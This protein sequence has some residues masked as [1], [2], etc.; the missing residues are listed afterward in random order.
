MTHTTT[1]AKTTA[2]TL[3]AS[4][5]ATTLLPV[6]S[7]D[8][9]QRHGVRKHHGKQYNRNHRRHAPVRHQKRRSNGDLIAAGIIGLAVGA[10]IADSASKQRQTQPTYVYREPQ[11]SPSYRQPLNTYQPRPAY[12]EPQVIRYNERVSY[13]PWTQAWYEYC[14]DRYR[15]FNANTGTFR[16]YDGKDHFCVAE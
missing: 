13:E 14:D 10:I 4:L 16:G 15:S 5:L 7:A 2:L 3:A 1:L 12:R 11:Y 9:G 8:A 6:A